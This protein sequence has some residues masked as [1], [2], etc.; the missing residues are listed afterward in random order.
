M[1]A[2]EQHFHVVLFIMLYKVV[3]AFE[4]LDETHGVTIQIKAEKGSTKC[5]TLFE[6]ASL[7]SNTRNPLH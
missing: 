1:K 4:F 5:K 3:L 7:M 6:I 2:I